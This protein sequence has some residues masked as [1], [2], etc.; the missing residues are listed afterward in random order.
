MR[1][2]RAKVGDLVASRKSKFKFRHHGRTETAWIGVVCDI[3]IFP[4]EID[5]D[6]SVYATD[7]LYT[8]LV[9]GTTYKM[10]DAVQLLREERDN[11]VNLSE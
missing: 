1:Y 2:K 11:F 3:H 4:D 7:D 6:G 5:D 10:K 9:F 8:I